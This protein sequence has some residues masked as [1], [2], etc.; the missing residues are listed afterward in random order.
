MKVTA[1][2]AK[3]TAHRL[4]CNREWCTY[5]IVKA[6][7]A[8][9]VKKTLSR[10]ILRA[11]SAT[12]P[13]SQPIPVSEPI[14]GSRIWSAL[15][16]TDGN[17]MGSKWRIRRRR[18][19]RRW[20]RAMLVTVDKNDFVV[21]VRS[22]YPTLSL[23]DGRRNGTM[24]V[25]SKPCSGAWHRRGANKIPTPVP[26]SEFS[27]DK[28]GR[29]YK[30]CD[31]CRDRSRTAFHGIPTPDRSAKNVERLVEDG[32]E[33]HKWEITYITT[34]SMTVYAKNYQGAGEAVGDVEILNIRRL[35]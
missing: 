12:P 21:S 17:D 2:T 8:L 10:T 16:D 26:L 30:T 13:F 4:I 34:S 18:N 5:V 9:Y 23:C 33:Q 1:R 28:N 35:D 20:K 6:T 22:D 3:T 27:F 24:P 7:R 29:Q 19:R 25:D 11:H 14:T 15:C 32:G 31:S